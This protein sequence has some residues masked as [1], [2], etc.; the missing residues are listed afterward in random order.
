MKGREDRREERT[1]AGK[2]R[3]RKTEGRVKK[4]KKK[5]W[6]GELVE[7]VQTERVRGREG[8]RV[9]LL[10][11]RLYPGAVMVCGDAGK[12]LK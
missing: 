1:K 8:K 4:K 5:G 11:P 3:E 9:I 10:I 2:S 6:R 12:S 7:R